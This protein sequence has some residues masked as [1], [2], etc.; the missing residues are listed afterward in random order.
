MTKIISISMTDEEYLFINEHELSP[1]R[2][3]KDALAQWMSSSAIMRQEI[4]KLKH[5]NEVM[6][7]QLLSNEEIKH[8]DEYKN[9]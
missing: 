8:G 5:A 7:K 9:D 6:Q 1:T 4:K 3:F 2:L